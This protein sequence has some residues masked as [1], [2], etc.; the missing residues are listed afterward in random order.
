MSSSRIPNPLEALITF[1]APQDLTKCL[2]ACPFLRHEIPT[3]HLEY[4]NLHKTS[5]LL[6]LAAEGDA[7]LLSSLLT[8]HP[9]VNLEQTN[10]RHQTPL[11]VAAS[12][13]HIDVVRL[14]CRHGAD[15]YGASSSSPYRTP[16]YWA[17]RYG[18]VAAMRYLIEEEGVETDPHR[19]S[20]KPPLLVAAKY[21]HLGAVD[22]LVELGRD[23][24]ALS[25]SVGYD[26]SGLNSG[27][28]FGLT[29]LLCA[30][31]NND[32]QIVAILLSRADLNVNVKFTVVQCT[33]LN[34]ACELGYLEIVGLLLGRRDLDVDWRDPDGWTALTWADH[35]GRHDVVR[36][37]R[38]RGVMAD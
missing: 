29:P 22:Y 14:L 15:R 34:I 2:R 26:I 31:M 23:P 3:K 9:R 32:A 5:I 7:E 18:Q 30:V 11:S 1:I 25:A 28:R 38:T 12:R 20:P 17:S 16:L 35:Y 10:R 6:V 4:R 36:L 37:L 27:D 19:S 21:R 13:G 8:H 33:P 24:N